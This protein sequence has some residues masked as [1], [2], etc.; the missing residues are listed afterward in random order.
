ML[1]TIC[2]QGGLKWLDLVVWMYF[3]ANKHIAPRRDLFFLTLFDICCIVDK[4]QRWWCQW[5][6]IVIVVVVVCIL[7]WIHIIALASMCG[8]HEHQHHSPTKLAKTCDCHFQT[9]FF[10]PLSYT[11]PPPPLHPYNKW[12][13]EWVSEWVFSFS[14]GFTYCCHCLSNYIGTHDA[15]CLM[16]LLIWGTFQKVFFGNGLIKIGC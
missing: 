12:S 10:L 1:F 8:M 2:S 4:I 14:C 5:E 9:T 11:N 16:K 13:Y 7:D 6:V 15:S 3:Y